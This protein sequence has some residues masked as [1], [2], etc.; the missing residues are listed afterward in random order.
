[1]SETWKP[2]AGYEGSYE[3]SSLGR[4]KSLPRKGAG[5]RILKAHL[6]K[7]GYPV[8]TLCVSNRKLT[9][10][11][12]HFVASAFIGKPDTRVEVNHKNFDKTDNRHDNLEWITHADNL[13]HA[14]AHFP[15]MNIATRFNLINNNST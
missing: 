12:H 14:M 3:V 11:V 15:L 1:M 13:R 2:I 4:I 6:S 7:D 9:R 10:P 8:V 5:G